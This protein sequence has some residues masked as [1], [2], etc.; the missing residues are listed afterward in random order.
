MN[1]RLKS[2]VPILSRFFFLL[3]TEFVAFRAKEAASATIFQP[4]NARGHPFLVPQR[5]R[6]PRSGAFF[7]SFDRDICRCD[8]RFNVGGKLL[9][10]R[11]QM[12]ITYAAI[13]LSVPFGALRGMGLRLFLAQPIVRR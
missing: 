4:A 5:Q 8:G 3:Y 1:F 7:T 9:S 10:I 2:D 12:A 6:W 11:Q 13:C